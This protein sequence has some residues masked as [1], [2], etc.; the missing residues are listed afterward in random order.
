MPKTLVIKLA[1]AMISHVGNCC[2]DVYNVSDAWYMHTSTTE[3]NKWTSQYEK[4]VLR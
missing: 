4:F 3:L 2:V 1:L